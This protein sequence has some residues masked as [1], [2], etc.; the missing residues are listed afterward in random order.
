[1]SWSAIHARSA[2]VDSRGPGIFLG[3]LFGITTLVLADN[4]AIYVR[5]IPP[6][7]M[8]IDAIRYRIQIVETVDTALDVG[9]YDGDSLVR[10]GSSGPT[11]GSLLPIGI[12]D[13]PLTAP[14]LLE[15]GKVYYSAIAPSVMT[16]DASV[17]AS[18]LSNAGFGL[19]L[20]TTAPDLLVGVQAA[21]HPLPATAALTGSS[22]LAAPIM[23]GL[24]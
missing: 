12:H 2:A 8:S 1:M 14:V 6:R 11:L 13:I 10:L 23:L 21:A 17:Q 3:P 22:A 20:G 4:Q 18:S 9:I 19:I 24:E 15:G 5:F 16:T 7:T